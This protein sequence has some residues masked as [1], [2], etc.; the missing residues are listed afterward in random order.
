MAMQTETFQ[1]SFPLPRSLDARIFIQLTVQAKSVII[2]LTTAAADETAN[3]PPMG[4]FVYALPDVSLRAFSL[5]SSPSSC[6][7]LGTRS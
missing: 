2:F 4:S 6:C 1:L 7:V 3:P 5:T